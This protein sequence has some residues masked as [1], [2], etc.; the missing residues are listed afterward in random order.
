MIDCPEGILLSSST[1]T[2]E[3]LLHYLAETNTLLFTISF[4]LRILYFHTYIILSLKVYKY[5]IFF[6]QISHTLFYWSSLPSFID[7]LTL[8]LRA[9]FTVCHLLNLS[10]HDH[11]MGVILP[12]STHKKLL[13]RILHYSLPL[14]FQKIPL[15][16]FIDHIT[17]HCCIVRCL[18]YMDKIVLSFIF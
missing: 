8:T 17:S 4:I 16:Y 15:S 18:F 10:P 12:S 13:K 2:L 1:I 7:H 11:P 14:L 6:Y 5:N 9:Y 3:K